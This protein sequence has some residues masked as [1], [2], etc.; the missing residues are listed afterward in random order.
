MTTKY[1][2]IYHQ[3]QF[4][5]LISSMLLASKALEGFSL[6][7]VGTEQTWQPRSLLIS[8]EQRAVST[9]W[10]LG[11]CCLCEVPCHYYVTWGHSKMALVSS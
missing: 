6:S 4:L 3:C 8:L 2:P 1:N 7:V 9:T 11:N 10:S 5:Q